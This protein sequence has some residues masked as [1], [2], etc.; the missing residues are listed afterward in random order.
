MTGYDFAVGPC[1]G[2]GR[3]FGFSAELV[4]SLIVK[5][6][7]QPICRDCVERV[8]PLRAERGLDPIMILRGA[9]DPEEA[10]R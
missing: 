5:G 2:C 1:F 4:P 3:L 7:R 6:K 9:Y 8:N 10:P